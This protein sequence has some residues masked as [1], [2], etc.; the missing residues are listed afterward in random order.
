MRG[1][2]EG[3]VVRR[4]GGFVREPFGLAEKAL[5]GEIHAMGWNRWTL[6]LLAFFGPVVAG[7]GRSDEGGATTQEAGPA[8]AGQTAPA[9]G[10]ADTVF[11]FLEAVR[12]GDD[13]KAAQMFTPLAR[14][15]VAALNI[16]IAP[17]GSD[18][19]RFEV[20][21]VALMPGQRASVA[22]IWTDLGSDGMPRTDDMTWMVRQ[23]AEGWRV[24]GMATMVFEGE[25]PLLLDF[26]NPE[27]TLHKLDLLREEIRRRAEMG[28]QQA[29]QPENSEGP[30]RR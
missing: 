11:Q 6:L 21:D 26:E 2:A 27:E 13:E 14:E 10:P 3:L 25:P 1:K 9:P 19:A 16:Q 12:T 7:C 28:T 24:A 18:T 4:D 30:V 8:A 5:F 20:R 17:Q 29:Q 23:V 22:A 15:R